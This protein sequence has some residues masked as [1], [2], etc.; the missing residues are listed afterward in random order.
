MRAVTQHILS[1]AD[2]LP[3]GRESFLDDIAHLLADRQYFSPD[4]LAARDGNEVGEVIIRSDAKSAAFYFG[5]PEE[6]K[7]RFH[8]GF[9]TPTTWGHGTRTIFSGSWAE[10]MI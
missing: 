10:R 5:N 7:R 4:D 9:S 2:E 8:D 1:L 6:T 3:G